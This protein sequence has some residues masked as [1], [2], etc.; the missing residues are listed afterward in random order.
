M[1]GIPASAYVPAMDTGVILPDVAFGTVDGA[2][3]HLSD[4]RG[5][6]VLLDFWTVDC[7]PC[8]GEM[9]NMEA[10]Y[11]RYKPRGLEIIG[12][13]ID[14][15]LDM[16]KFSEFLAQQ[17][18]T[19]THTSLSIQPTGPELRTW[20]DVH[21][22]L[23]AFPTVVLLGPDGKIVAMDDELRGEALQK[24]LER[25]IPAQLTKQHNTL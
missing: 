12:V 17:G 2:S 13:D 18:S 22:R 16:T 7:G 1:T 10:A 20:I 15:D 25:F 6:Y 19:W 23:H 21:C 9:P 24:T 14:N 5:K 8:I 11:Q 3:H 4:Y